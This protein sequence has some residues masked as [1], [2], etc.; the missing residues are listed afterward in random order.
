MMTFKK[1]LVFCVTFKTNGFTPLLANKK[2][3]STRLLSSKIG[4]FFGSST[5]SVS[6]FDDGKLKNFFII[7]MINLHSSIFPTVQ[8][9]RRLNLLWK[10]LEVKLLKDHSR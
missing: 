8:P 1:L 7:L 6:S 2:I 10:N 3:E 9:N 4:V 5:G